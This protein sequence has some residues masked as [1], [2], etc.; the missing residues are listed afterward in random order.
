[1]S[2]S[3]KRANII[4]FKIFNSRLKKLKIFIKSKF[5]RENVI[6]NI[7]YIRCNIFFIK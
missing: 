2:K 5:F 7:N 4:N 3:K 1:M 6:I